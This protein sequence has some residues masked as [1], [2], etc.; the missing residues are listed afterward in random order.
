MENLSQ[1]PIEI[2]LK[3][4]EEAK[5]ESRITEPT[6]MSL[7]TSTKDG[8]PSVR[9]VLLKGLDERGFVFYTNL[10]S[11]KASELKE[12]PKAA[13]CLY[14]MLLERQVRVEGKIEEVAAT[15][16]DEYFATRHRDSQIGAWASKQSQVLEE[17]V[18]LLQNI[19]E[20]MAEFEGRGV[21]R[22]DFW[23]GFR[24]VPDKIEI[25][26]QGDFRLHERRLFTHV[27]EGWKSVL[28]YP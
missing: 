19:S 7:A 9:M 5:N 23:S 25:W 27:A 12:N 6:A 16:A 13:L 24:V 11:R 15:E 26:Q 2:T 21:P 8:I 18:D 10:G 28:L 3:W 22:P 4:L 17:K 20:R 1:N 14:W